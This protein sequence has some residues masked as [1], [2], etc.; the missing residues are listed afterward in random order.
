LDTFRSSEIVPA[1]CDIAIIGAGLAGVSTAYHILSSPGPKPS[2][3]IFEAREACSGATGRNGGHTKT[4]PVSL[5]SMQAQ[6]GTQVAAEFAAVQAAQLRAM[7]AV[8]E[9]EEIECDFLVT[10]SFDVFFDEEQAA[11]MKAWVK[12]QHD[13]GADWLSGV[14]WLEGPNLERVSCL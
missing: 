1:E 5:K 13:Q 2:V 12:E 6:F 8:V 11:E 3:A 9:K 7:K 14:Q 10:R 4:S